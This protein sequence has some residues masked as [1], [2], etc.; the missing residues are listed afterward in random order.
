MGWDR[1]QVSQA[2]NVRSS[3]DMSETVIGSS[4]SLRAAPVLVVSRGWWTGAWLRALAAY[5]LLPNLV[6]GILG[7][8]VYVTRAL[9]NVD[10]LL[11]GCV[12]GLLPWRMVTVAYVLLIANDAFVSLSPVFHFGL[13]TAV[14]S[15]AFGLS[16]RLALSSTAVLFATSASAI[17]IV[18]ERLSGIRGTR[19]FRPSLLVAAILI[20]ALDIF[21]GTSA[22]SHADSALLRVNLATSALYKTTKTIRQGMAGA[23]SGEET[24]KPTTVMAATDGIRRTLTSGGP[25]SALG[26]ADVV[27]VL[28][29]SLGH[30][31]AAGVDSQVLAPLLSELVTRRYEVRFGTVPAHGATTNGELRELCQAG[32]DYRMVRQVKVRDCLPALLRKNGFRT[33]AVHGYSQ[34]FFDR[35]HWY[36]RVGFEEMRFGEEL[37]HVPGI[38]LCGSTFRGVCDA[39]VS[40]VL[41]HQLESAPRGGRRFVY[42]LTLSSHLPL[43]A[44]GAEGS[45]LDCG[46]SAEGR[47][48]KDVCVLMR[49]HRRVATEVA[50]IAMDPTLRP[51][52]FVLVGDH[53]PPFFSRDKRSLFVPDAVP[54]VELIPRRVEPLPATQAPVT[55]AAGV[56]GR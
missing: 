36:P 54:F 2:R 18:G 48:F 33:I 37:T 20:V 46:Q 13:E 3:L 12:A 55:T 5:L 17:A 23:A 1:H 19:V 42:W 16:R 35:Y 6:F 32:A 9:I 26:G 14:F 56:S 51:T 43:D 31:S 29:E 47:H 21:G 34:E 41:K 45:T 39:D 11:L 7:Q 10:Y 4:H 40:K 28:V 44:A 49:I 8:F 30:F 38:T 52:R 53:T 24:A 22:F 25:V 50:A 27:L 15:L